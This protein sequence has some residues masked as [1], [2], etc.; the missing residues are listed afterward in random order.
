M[1][2]AATLNAELRERAGKG[3]ARATR[4]AGRVPAVIY[5]NKQD[6]VIIT[7]DPLE[8]SMELR[9]PGFFSRVFE[10]QVDGAKHRVLPRDLQL[11]PVT[12]IPMH[13]DF[14]RFSAKTRLAID[15]AVIF[16]NEEESPG[17]KGGGVLNIVRHTI[18][19]M[20]SPD[21]I[22]ES[23]S[24]DLTG[25]EVGDSVHISS[26]KLPDDVELTIVD[27]DFTVATIAAPTI[28]V[29]VEEE[30]VELDENGEP[31]IPVEDEDEAGGEGEDA[32]TEEGEAKE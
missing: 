10:L 14:M 32:A 8:L 30:E 13:V 7:L 25:L 1:A 31:I 6:P 18:E 19:L 22:P 27:R 3:A 29:D 12:D 24:V 28:I 15:V 23:L 11:H 21:S 16:E 5:G 17:I 26:I 4:R 9:G 2:Q 20:C